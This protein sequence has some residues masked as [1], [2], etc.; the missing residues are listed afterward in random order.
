MSRK[1]EWGVNGKCVLCAHRARAA[2]VRVPCRFP[3]CLTMATATLSGGNGFG[4]SLRPPIGFQSPPEASSRP[5]VLSRMVRACAG[6]E[7]SPHAGL[8]RG[9]V[10]VR[11]CASPNPGLLRRSVRRPKGLHSFSNLDSLLRPPEASGRSMR[12]CLRWQVAQ[13]R[14]GR[15]RYK[16]DES[17]RTSQTSGTDQGARQAR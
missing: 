1:A 5:T 12:I 9:G 2:R 4:L 17:G 11:K 16:T 6:R 8:A 13:G 10:A 3:V 15:R 7:H 14:R